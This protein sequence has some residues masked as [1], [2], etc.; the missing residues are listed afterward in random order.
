MASRPL[1][2]TEAVWGGQRNN[3]LLYIFIDVLMNDFISHKTAIECR[4]VQITQ[5]L[6]TVRERP[7]PFLSPLCVCV[8]VCVFISTLAGRSLIT[9]LLVSWWDTAVT[10]SLAYASNV[11]ELLFRFTCVVLIPMENSIDQR[12]IFHSSY[13]CNITNISSET[14][15]TKDNPPGNLMRNN[16]VHVNIS[17]F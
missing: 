7:L 1:F 11:L 9:Q 10:P 2:T 13:L 16:W 15:K 8:C 3:N 17:E 12:L 14:N 5:A 6:I 4:S